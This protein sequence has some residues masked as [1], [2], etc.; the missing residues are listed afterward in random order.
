[1]YDFT[2]STAPGCRLPHF[3]L[4]DGRSLYDALDAD[5]TLVRLDRDLPVDRLLIA[6]SGRGVPIA[7]LDLDPSTAPAEY[8]HPLL[9]VRPDRHIAWRGHSLPDDAEGIVKLVSAGD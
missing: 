5:F 7:L 2:P 6:A 8:R 1:M 9:L 4:P 3:T